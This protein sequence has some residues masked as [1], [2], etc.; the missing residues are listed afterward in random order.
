MR[1]T[2]L[3]FALLAG[4]GSAPSSPEASESAESSG[5]SIRFEQ[6]PGRVDVFYGDAPLTAF[7]Y[8][9]KWDKPFLY[10]IVTP[11]GKTLSRGYPVADR[12]GEHTDHIW[13]RGIWFGHGEINGEDFW[14]EKGRDQTAV[15]VPAG[16]P[17]V[18][19]NALSA[20]LLMRTPQ[21]KQLGSIS[22][23]FA[24]GQ[25]QDL[26]TIDARIE[27]LADQGEALT[28]GDTEDG[29]F[30]FRLSDAFREDMGGILRNAEGLHG[31][32][33][34]WGKP[35]RWVDY[36]AM[37]DGGLAGVALFDHPRNLRHPTRWHARNYSLNAANP[38]GLGDFTGDESA[39]GSYTIP[40]GGTL[41][42]QYRV[43]IYDGSPDL[44]ALYQGFAH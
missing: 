6:A 18:Q 27:V 12:P 11:S 30:A 21:G 42:L 36:S 22:E 3:L 40:A 28:L 8:E 32:D 26:R 35:A 4:C 41:T 16:E 13:H 25:E 9:E 1:P 33:N 14:R 20:T 39:D 34:I 31:A 5:P 7:H 23:T 38:F 29:G 17:T 15:L 37:I 44:E 24:F 10:P 2:L 19:G 43:V